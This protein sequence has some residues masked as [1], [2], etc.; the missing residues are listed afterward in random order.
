MPGYPRVQRLQGPGAGAHCTQDTYPRCDPG[1]LPWVLPWVGATHVLKGA[2]PVT[3][4][5]CCVF[6]LRWREQKSIAAKQ[7]KKAGHTKRV[8]TFPSSSSLPTTTQTQRRTTTTTTQ[9][10]VVV[11]ATLGRAEWDERVKALLPPAAAAISLEKG[12]IARATGARLHAPPEA[13]R[14]ARGHRVGTCVGTP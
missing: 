5:S 9:Q 13:L 4:A 12:K 1:V 8:L 2:E 7:Q 3:R 10:L 6:S 14:Q 11:A